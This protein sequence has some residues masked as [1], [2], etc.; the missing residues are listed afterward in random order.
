MTITLELESIYFKT[1]ISITENC[2]KVRN[3]ELVYI[4]SK[5]ETITMETG[6]S[7]EKMGKE[8]FIMPKQEENMMVFGEKMGNMVL[9]STSIQIKIFMKEIGKKTKSLGREHFS[10]IK[11]NPNTEE[12]GQTT[13]L[14]EKAL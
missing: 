10:F 9:E 2:K 4:N 6:S 7:I 14:M 11:T 12:N 1:E 3:M 5:M 8:F 13:W